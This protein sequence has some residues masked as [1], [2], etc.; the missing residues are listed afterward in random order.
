MNDLFLKHI[1]HICRCFSKVKK[2]TVCLVRLS[3]I[4]TKN[5]NGVKEKLKIGGNKGKMIMGKDNRPSFFK[6]VF[7]VASNVRLVS[8]FSLS[9]T[10]K[11][12]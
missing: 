10:F 3:F 9:S 2:K 11:Y 8:Y 6:I 12:T 7:D 4:E 5:E 1:L